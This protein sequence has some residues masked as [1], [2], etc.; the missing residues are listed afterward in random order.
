MAWVASNPEV[1]IGAKSTWKEA[2]VETYSPWTLEFQQEVK[3]AGMY[4]GHKVLHKIFL[5]D[6]TYSRLGGMIDSLKPVLEGV[7]ESNGWTTTLPGAKRGVC[8]KPDDTYGSWEFTKIL[9]GAELKKADAGKLVWFIPAGLANPELALRTI[10]NVPFATKD[11][12]VEVNDVSYKVEYK[13]PE[14][15]GQQAVFSLKRVAFLKD[16]AGM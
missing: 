13:Y 11:I 4:G 6:G 7:Y 1:D 8:S 5:R 14:A 10:F 15:T 3:A 9:T 12:V 16:K 2:A